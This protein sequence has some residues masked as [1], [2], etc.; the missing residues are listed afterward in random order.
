MEDEQQPE[1]DIV[2]APES[3]KPGKGLESTEVL[4]Y[5]ERRVHRWDGNPYELD[6]GDWGYGEEAGTTWLSPYWLGRYH[7]FIK[8]PDSK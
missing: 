7:G 6:G 5:K 3:M 4:P 1:A 8:V 2:I